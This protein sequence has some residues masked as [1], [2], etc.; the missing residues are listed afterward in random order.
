M[1]DEAHYNLLPHN[2]F[3]IAA[4][5]DRFVQIDSSSEAQRFLPSLAATPLL[6]IGR[7]SNLLLTADFA[8]VVLRSNIR[9]IE[10][11][12]HDNDTVLLRCGSGE[13]WDDVVAYAVAHGLYGAE[14]LSLIPG[15]VGAA[16]VQNIGAYGAEI[17]DILYNVE[18]VE[19]A[20]GKRYCFSRAECHYA[21]RDS[22]FKREWRNRFFITHVSLC[23]RRQ[24]TPLLTYGNV[25]KALAERDIK[26]PSAEQLRSTI[27][28][29]RQDKLPDPAV[30]GNAGSFFTNP[31]VP[32]E[33]CA[34]LRAIYPDMPCYAADNDKVKLS[35]AW[36]IEQAGW[37]GRALGRAAVYDKQAVVLVNRGGATGSDILALCRVLQE[38][39]AALFSVS[40]TPEVNI[41]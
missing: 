18:A 4:F 26:H 38:T 33:Q 19:I 35:A 37:K 20:S 13:Q 8:G 39:V 27:I 32:R 24:F 41:V 28:S 5:C 11:R 9:G 6:L 31:I 10:V 23:L 12:P 30:L 36:L 34:R 1:T 25:M 2:T 7:G 22:R 29:L 14:N 16:A 21:Y 15:D 3:G 40:L 17:Q